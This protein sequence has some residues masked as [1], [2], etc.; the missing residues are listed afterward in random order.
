MRQEGLNKLN[1]PAQLIHLDHA[2]SR[3]GYELTLL[4]SNHSQTFNI[5]I[6][7]RMLGGIRKL[8]MKS[9]IILQFIFLWSKEHT[10]LFYTFDRT[11]SDLF[12]IELL[13]PIQMLS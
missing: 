3:I 9:Q 1:R 6:K 5:H 8:K 7:K 4:I 2:H 12:L 13:P 10:L 11:R